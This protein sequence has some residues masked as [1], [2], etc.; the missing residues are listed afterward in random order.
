[1]CLLSNRPD[2]LRIR[3]P[4]WHEHRLLKR[5][6]IDLHL[7]VFSE[8]SD[9]I[10]RLLVFRDR[11]RSDLQDR[12]LYARRKRELA[13]RRWKYGQDYADAKTDVVE[14]ILKRAIDDDIIV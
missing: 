2:T 12:E 4:D 8:G 5:R 1:M 14:F 11:L 7:H 6:D 9:E 3:E 10:R 13:G